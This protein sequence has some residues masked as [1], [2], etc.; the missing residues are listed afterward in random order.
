LDNPIKIKLIRNSSIAHEPEISNTNVQ[1]YN[2]NRLVIL[3]LIYRIFFSG[4]ACVHFKY[5]IFNYIFYRRLQV[6][7]KTQVVYNNFQSFYSF[8][9]RFFQRGGWTMPKV[10]SQCYS[11][12]RFSV[13]YFFYGLLFYKSKYFSFLIKIH[14]RIF[15]EKG[16]SNANNVVYKIILKI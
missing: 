5:S 4:G 10:E 7:W 3:S 9:Y 12:S 8:K 14:D 16:I 15:S 6:S 11:T 13:Q 2:T 1:L